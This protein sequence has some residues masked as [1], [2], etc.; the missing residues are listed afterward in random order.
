MAEPV[1]G[2]DLSEFEF[3]LP[4]VRQEWGACVG[5]GVAHWAIASV[6]SP[7]HFFLACQG[8][9]EAKGPLAEF[10]LERIA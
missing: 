7:D 6:T 2:L 10:V 5:D 8:C 9:I 4:C 1:E 3:E